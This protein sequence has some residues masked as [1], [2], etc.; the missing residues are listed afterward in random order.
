M[1]PASPALARPSRGQLVHRDRLIVAIAQPGLAL[2]DQALPERLGVG[3]VAIVGVDLDPHRQLG[4]AVEDLAQ[5][6]EAVMTVG[7]IQLAVPAHHH[8]LQR[9]GVR[10]RAF[11]QLKVSGLSSRAACAWAMLAKA[12][13]ACPRPC[14]RNSRRI[15]CRR[16]GSGSRSG[17]RYRRPGGTGEI[18][19]PAAQLVV[20]LVVADGGLRGIQLFDTDLDHIARLRLQ[21]RLV[22]CRCFRRAAPASRAPARA[23]PPVRRRRCR[24]CRRPAPAAAAPRRSGARPEMETGKAGESA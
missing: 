1:P 2:I 5:R 14:P 10:A 16:C 24:H 7:E 11:R 23:A 22:L 13:R 4:P 12:A 17:W 20:D 21:V 9:G 18:A 3:H 19:L 6:R 15:S 8:G